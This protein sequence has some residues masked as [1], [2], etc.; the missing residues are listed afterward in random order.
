MCDIK[1]FRTIH[2][3]RV[4]STSPVTSGRPCSLAPAIDGVHC[5]GGHHHD[6][7]R[8][9]SDPRSR[10]PGLRALQPEEDSDP[11]STG[12]ARPIRI[13]SAEESLPQVLP[14]QGKT[15]RR[16]TWTEESPPQV[17]PRQGKTAR[18]TRVYNFPSIFHRKFTIPGPPYNTRTG[19]VFSVH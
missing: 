11:G 3:P 4:V 14:R 10:Q 17:L 12:R 18:R 1:Y 9:H 5:Q 8:A 13:T 2:G 19:N 15:A 6:P 16:I 7:Q